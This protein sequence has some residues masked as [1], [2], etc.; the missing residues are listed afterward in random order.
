MRIINNG[1]WM[2]FSVTFANYSTTGYPAIAPVVDAEHYTGAPSPSTEQTQGDLERYDPSS[3]SWVDLHFLGQGT[4]MD[5]MG[6]GDAARFPLPVNATVSIRYRMFLTPQDK[7]GSLGIDA[8]AV[9]PPGVTSEMQRGT[10][11]VPIMVVAP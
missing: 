5:F 10:I 6:T 1:Q 8:L 7:P 9:V 2:D 11:S 3:G 4:G